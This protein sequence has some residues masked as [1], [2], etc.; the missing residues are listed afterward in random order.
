MLAIGRALMSAP[1]LLA[2]DEPSM[3]L[4]PLYV[5]LVLDTVLELK[6]RGRTVLLVEQLA[7]AALS[8]ADRAYVLQTGEVKLSGPARD[9]LRDRSVVQTYLGA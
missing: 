6:A 9:L 2:M 4:A 8:I 1:D 7:T 3:G 5:K